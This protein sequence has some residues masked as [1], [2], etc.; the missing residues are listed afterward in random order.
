MDPE[1]QE[2]GL[3]LA[4]SLEVACRYRKRVLC[5]IGQLLSTN[6]H[7]EGGELGQGAC[8]EGMNDTSVLCIGKASA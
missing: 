4:H 1:Q 3:S 7:W 8:I 2:R 6:Q 5:A